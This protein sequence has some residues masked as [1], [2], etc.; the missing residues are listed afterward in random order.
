MNGMDFLAIRQELG[1]TQRQMAEH[2]GYS[3]N[4]YARLERG[5]IAIPVLVTRYMLTLRSVNRLARVMG[6][7]ETPPHQRP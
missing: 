1:W 6:L 2:L 7:F 3:V 4:H 5:D